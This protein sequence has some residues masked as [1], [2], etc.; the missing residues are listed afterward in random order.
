MA[1]YK[2]LKARVQELAEREW[3]M[4]AIEDRYEKL[5]SRGILKK[6]LNRDEILA[7]R[8]QI[9]DRVQRRGLKNAVL[10]REWGPG[11]PPK[12]LLRV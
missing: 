9:L 5:A 1:D 6:T 4:P 11:W 10:C 12:S 8:E 3:D 2:A 7:D